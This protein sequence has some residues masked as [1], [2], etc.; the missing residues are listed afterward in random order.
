MC[1]IIGYVGDDNAIKKLENGLKNL[2]YRGYDSAGISFFTDKLITI[3]KTGYVNNLFSFVNSNIT[4]NIGIGHTRWATHGKVCDKNSHPQNSNLNKVSIVHNGIIENYKQLYNSYLN[5]ISLS[6]ETDTEII[7]N[8]IEKFYIEFN[9][10]LKAIKTTIKLLKGSFAIAIL[11]NDDKKNIYF[12]KNISPLVIG[13]TNKEK[14]I[15]SD[16]LGFSN[17]CS[18]FIEIQDMQFGYISKDN[19]NIFDLE[20]KLIKAKINKIENKNNNVTKDNFPFYMYKEINEIPS[21]LLN[22]INL[23]IGKYSP[24][25]NIPI[26]FFKNIKKIKLVACGTSYHACMYASKILNEINFDTSYEI[27]S[28]FIYEKQNIDKDTLCIFISQSGETADTLS[29][30][31]IAKKKKAKTLG[32]TNVLT[33]SITKLCDYILP[34]NCGNEIA[35]ASTKAF[36][37]Q[38][39][40]LNLLTYFLKNNFLLKSNYYK[41][42]KKIFENINIKLYEQQISPLIEKI[43]HTKNT[44]IVGKS[45]DYVISLETALKIKE[46]TYLNCSAYPSGELKHGTISLIDENSIVLAFITD[47]KLINKTLNVVNQTQARNAKICL[48]TPFEDIINDSIENKIILP[49]INKNLMPIISI[50]PMQLLAYHV[51]LSLNYNPD[52]P[53]FLAKSVTVE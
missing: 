7:A 46:I 13:I 5:N 12:A 30:V 23:Y 51:S 48:I 35:V 10:K 14:F 34:I 38:L 20:N 27:A 21:C 11:F 45:L 29:A 50:I 32:I 42:L 43:K 37:C 25:N 53:R 52:K 15:S 18:K 28:E 47:K 8:L 22:T 19:V 39:L 26:S 4:S 36:N 16:I 9:D 24:L 17:K 33:S 31:K 3:K 41:N 1:G 49:K 2:E 44:F 6:S 40:V